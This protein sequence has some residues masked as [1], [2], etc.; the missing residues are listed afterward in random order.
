MDSGVEKG[1]SLDEIG[2]LQNLVRNLRLILC[3]S[4]EYGFGKAAH[5]VGICG[6]ILFALLAPVVLLKRPELGPA[7]GAVAGGWLFVSRLILDPIKR[8]YKQRGARAQEMFD[9]AVLG[10]A[11]N[12]AISPRLPVEEIH[13]ST[14]RWN[15]A[16]NLS[17][18]AD[19]ASRSLRRRVKRVSR[20]RDWYATG[21]AIEWPMS[22]L[23]CQRA[24]VV[25]ARRQH[26]RYAWFLIA[27]AV[28]WFVIG[29][30]V[31]TGNETSL[32]D[33]LVVI[34]LPSLPAFL[35][36]VEMARSHFDSSA[37][38]KELEVVIDQLI[39]DA[40]GTQASLRDV[41][42]QIFGLRSTDPL[43]PNLFHRV[44]RPLFEQD[45]R[46]AVS[47]EEDSHVAN[48]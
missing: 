6:A 7:L 38:R 1:P 3:A 42:D 27:V 22:S 30:A 48:G 37:Q 16:L 17:G 44:I 9:C 29:L 41:Q 36:A 43:V 2:S 40:D 21:A 39:E 10:L 26:F 14:R 15:E 25:W 18:S 35:D 23:Q 5:L 46:Y 47:D 28:I 13:G 12:D 32:A 24:N 33:Y 20:V 4:R 19:H 11:W 34:L 31:S 45:M 8:H